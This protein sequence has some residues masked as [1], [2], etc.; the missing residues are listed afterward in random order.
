MI[1]GG[2]KDPCT[3]DGSTCWK[4][5]GCL[6]SEWLS[7][8]GNKFREY[9]VFFFFILVLLSGWFLCLRFFPISLKGSTFPTSIGFEGI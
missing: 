7:V 1:G 2:V 8:V 3:L 4:I 6:T 5:K 9:I